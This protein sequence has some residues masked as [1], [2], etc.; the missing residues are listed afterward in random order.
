M[1]SL[2]LWKLLVFVMILLLCAC[3]AEKEAVQESTSAESVAA[4]SA[5]GESLTAESTSAEAGTAIS[6]EEAKKLVDEKEAVFIDL[7]QESEYIGW[8]INSAEGGHIAGA[9][10]FPKDW[11]SMFENNEKIYKDLERRGVQR[12]Q[13][14]ILYDTKDVEE[15]VVKQFSDLGFKVYSLQ[16]GI[17]GWIAAK[18]GELEK[19]P[20][21][22][23]LVYPQWVQD[24][25]EGKNPYSAEGKEWKVIELSFGATEPDYEAGHIKGALHV[26]NLAID[27][28][29][30]Q[31]LEDY[32]LM[33]FEEKKSY[34]T[35]PSDEYIGNMMKDLGIKKDTLVVVYGPKP[36][37]SARLALI[38]RYAGVED[39]RIV[40]GGIK[41]IKAD[42]IP[43]E[44]GIVTP[45]PIDKLDVNIPENPEIFI[46]LET[47]KQLINDPNA[48]IVSIRSWKEYIGEVIGYT[49]IGEAG[50]IANAKFGYAGSDPYHLE[51]FRNID[52]TMFSYPVIEKRWELWGITPDKKLS[53]HCGTGWRAAEAMFY[54]MAMGYPDVGLYS[55]GWY[56][57]TLYP[58][59]PRREKGVPAD[60]PEIPAHDFE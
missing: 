28:P 59:L 22:E 30:P 38:L 51:D 50:D 60:A 45:S 56:E 48:V 57:W 58:E 18:A 13:T 34:F 7:R 3:A 33:S 39:V 55:N 40:N 8:K 2:N 32:K 47:E 11:F 54:A 49:F 17:D 26:T 16:G 29:G 37:A 9:V 41:R 31:K 20:H 1:K 35:K 23:L 46:D 36:Y 15:S 25:V 44:S 43:L 53:F 21:Y 6:I 5:S 10:D 24:L 42:N 19:L 52:E 14:L 27:V 12:E 4:E